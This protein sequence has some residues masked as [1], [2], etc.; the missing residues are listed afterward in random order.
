[1]VLKKRRI[2]HTELTKYPTDKWTAQHLREATPWGK[3][4]KFLIRDRDRKYAM[5]FSAVAVYFGIKQLKTPY[6]TSQANGICE[7]FRGSLRREC[8]DHVLIQEGRHLEWVVKEHTTYFN[9]ERPHLG[10][11]Q[12]IPNHIELPKSKPTSG[13]ITSKAILSGLHHS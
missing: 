3:G 4:L 13:R 1:M 7:R 9:Q 12:C 5:H 11:D 2:T 10:I 6:R 8:L